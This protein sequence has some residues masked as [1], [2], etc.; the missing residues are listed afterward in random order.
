MWR[1]FFKALFAAILEY[2]RERKLA[3]DYEEALIENARFDAEALARA[4]E[5]ATRERIN[6]EQVAMGDDPA[7][8]RERM[9][10]RDP[11]QN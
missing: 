7:V 5:A 10:L 8:L 9:R 6:R 2:L 1:A 3:Q 4:G 11:N